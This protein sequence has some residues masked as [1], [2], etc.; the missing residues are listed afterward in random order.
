M[1]DRSTCELGTECKTCYP[2]GVKSFAP[3]R[4]KHAR[5]WGP[6]NHNVDY[7][8]YDGTELTTIL[9]DGQRIKSDVTV[10]DAER[11]VKDGD[12]VSFQSFMPQ[13]VADSSGEWAG[14]ALR[15]ATREE[16]EKNVRD[17]MDRWLSVTDT[18]VVE[19]GDEP[20]YRWDDKVGLVRLK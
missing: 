4:Y 17:L 10:N 6:L 14:N 11:Y 7:V 9:K 8:E 5:G 16:A 15:F 18:R 19:S 12:W 2:H 1:H 20:N 13:V 3:K